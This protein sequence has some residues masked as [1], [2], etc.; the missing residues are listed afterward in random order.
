M[1]I[2]MTS[3][4]FYPH[5][6]GIETVTENMATEFSRMEGIEVKVVTT[7]SDTG[8]KTFPFEVY[9]NPDR[10]TLWR[11][12]K[13]CDVFVHQGISLKW[14]WPWLVKRKPW[15]I[16]YHQPQFQKGYLGRIK[17]IC[18]HLTARN[19]AVS[20]DVA[21]GCGLTNCVTI[22]NTYNSEVYKRTN[23][24]ERRDIAFVGRINRDKGV[25]ILLDAYEKFKE[26][27]GSDYTLTMIGTNALHPEEHERVKAYAGKLKH[28]RGVKFTGALFPKDIAP[29]LNKTK[30]LAT[31]SIYDEAFG[32]VCL[33]GMACG[34]V[35]IGSDGDGIAEAINGHGY[36]FRKGDSNELCEK[37]K[38][39][40]MLS[41][42]E[43][44]ARWKG[45]AAWLEELA[46]PNVAKR[47]VEVFSKSVK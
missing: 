41:Q 20:E 15:F 13:W 29:I 38:A 10:K 12:Y 7:T 27:T 31:P 45:T 18:S 46:L 47:Y 25:Y 3:V 33:E 34:C 21:R 35:V 8:S 5:I 16:V 14:V 39:A 32:V 44:S 4:F 43:I 42:E 22:L 19:I 17:K 37:I 40:A 36:L 9:R 11:L 2:L 28:G 1:K 26:E 23:E 30:F 24:K 6:G